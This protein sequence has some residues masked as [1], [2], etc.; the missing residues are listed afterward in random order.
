MNNEIKEILYM[1]KS[2]IDEPNKTFCANATTCYVLLYHITN[3]EQE[4][5]KLTAEST[6]WEERTYHWQDRAEYFNI[7]IDKA[8]E[9]IK[10]NIEDEYE[11]H[12]LLYKNDDKQKILNILTGDDE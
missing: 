12:G 2:V 9:Y 10:T 8:V 7:R 6:E 1:L 5:N 3:L 11:Y 4:I